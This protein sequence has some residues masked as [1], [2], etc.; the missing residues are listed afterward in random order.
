MITLSTIALALSSHFVSAEDNENYIRMLSEGDN[1]VVNRTQPESICGVN[2]LQ[3]VERYDNRYA[4]F[5]FTQSF[6]DSNERSVGALKS[7]ASSS[8]GSY[9]SGTLIS[10]NLFL[11]AAHCV[12]GTTVN[13]VVA[14]NYQLANDTNTVRAQ[15]FFN[16][17]RVA[18]NGND[19]PG[20]LD[21]AILE[22]EGAP[23]N[24]YGWKT[25][26]NEFPEEIMII[27]HPQGHPKQLDAG[28]NFIINGNRILYADLDTMGGSSGSGILDNTG[29]IIGVHTNGGC[30]ITTGRNSGVTSAAIHQVSPMLPLSNNRTIRAIDSYGTNV[31]GWLVSKHPRVL[32]DINGDGKDDIVGFG[33]ISVFTSLANGDGT[34]ASP[35]RALNSFTEQNGGWEV[36]KHP[37]MLADINGDG[38]ADII[39]FGTNSVFTAL[40]N[41]DGTFASIKRAID[42]YTVNSGKWEVAK[43][44]RVVADVN[45]DGL[46]DIVGFGTNSV[47]TSLSRGD[48]TFAPAKVALNAFTYNSGNWRVESHPRQVGDIN[49]DGLADI[50]GFGG[51]GVYTS[52]GRGDGTFAPHKFVLSNYALLAGKWEVSKHPRVLS[53]VNGDGLQDIV[54]FGG[55]DVY[56]SFARGDGTFTAPTK[57]HDEFVYTKG[58]FVDKH[59]RQ[60]ADVN[61]DGKADIVGFS[62]NGVL[63]YLTR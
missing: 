1:Y 3:H 14:F 31:G 28:S 55:A 44:P 56:T 27:Q 61:G 8:A 16:I 50:V 43:H 49:G 9:C 5:G 17:T 39:G 41:G 45:G 57:H 11:T 34:F 37:R 48:G 10:S 18:E 23:G 12:D 36:S 6:V 33:G 51:E 19:L 20:R 53:D 22:L 62:D 42:A 7:V 46:A 4:R 63:V 40:S 38:L 35:K 30:G 52:L 15:Q 2:D 25:L 32:A 29:H 59:P 24:N 21:Y 60:V 13:D 58:W 47:F 26:R 54:G